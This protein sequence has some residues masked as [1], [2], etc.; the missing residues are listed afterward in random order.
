MEV[1]RGPGQDGEEPGSSPSSFPGKS[2]QGPTGFAEGGAADVLAPG[3]GLAGRLAAVTGGDGAG[4]G[5]L[6]DLEVLGVLAAGGRM[7]AWAG[8]GAAGGGG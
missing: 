1:V 3:A 6:G 5:S 2:N 4:L 7:A 8:W